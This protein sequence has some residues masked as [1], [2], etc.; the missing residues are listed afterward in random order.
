MRFKRNQNFFWGEKILSM[1]DN[2]EQF[3][4]DMNPL[5]PDFL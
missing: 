3:Y 5:G 2:Q 1:Q 4:L